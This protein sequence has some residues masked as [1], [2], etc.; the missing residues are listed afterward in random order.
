MKAMNIADSVKQKLWERFTEMS[1]KQLDENGYVSTPQENLLPKINL[2]DF[3][4]DYQQGSGNELDN[5]FLAIHSSSAL[6]ANSFAPWRKMPSELFLCGKSGFKEISFEKKCPTGL[7]GTPPNLDLF[8]KGEG[9]IIGVESKLSEYLIQK[10][11]KFS[12]SYNRDNLRHIEDKW[13]KVLEDK[14]YESK[15]QHLDVAQLIKHYLGLCNRKD[16]DKHRAILLYLF[17]EPANWNEFDVFITHR[18]E[19]EEFAEQV[20]GTSIKFIAQSYPELWT[21]WENQ[22]ELKY[23]EHLVNLRHRYVVTI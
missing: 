22:I 10:P 17:W 19:I 5:K 12:S 11:P 14:K 6:V 3:E 4:T 1:G 2:V 13:W 18:R 8:V 7:R 15:P 16:I 20:D 9:V 21:E 23:R